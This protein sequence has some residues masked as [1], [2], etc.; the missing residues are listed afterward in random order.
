MDDIRRILDKLKLCIP[1]TTEDRII[2]REWRE[3]EIEKIVLLLKS[4][5]DVIAVKETLSEYCEKYG[6]VNIISI[7]DILPEQTRL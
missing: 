4:D 1:L 3:K 5:A 7:E 2:L 6:D